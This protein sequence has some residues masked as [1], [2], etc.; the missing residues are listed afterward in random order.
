M[1]KIAFLGGFLL[2]FIADATDFTLGSSSALTVS[3]M[4]FGRRLFAMLFQSRRVE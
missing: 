3:P 2:L 4:P 1:N